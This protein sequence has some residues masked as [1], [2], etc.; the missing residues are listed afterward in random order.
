MFQG[1]LGFLVDAGLSVS[2]GG[3]P[4]LVHWPLPKRD[5]MMEKGLREKHEKWSTLVCFIRNMRIEIGVSNWR[6]G[7]SFE[8]TTATREFGREKDRYQ[9]RS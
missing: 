5:P 2:Q 8:K 4:P 1:V 3:S 9:G 7:S 6:D